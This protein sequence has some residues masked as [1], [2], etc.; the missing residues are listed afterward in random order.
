MPIEDIPRNLRLLCG[1]GRSVS[2]ICRQSGVNRH[3]MKRYLAGSSRP[4]LHTLRR[5]CD[6]FGVEEQELL[7]RHADFAALVR[8]RPPR[9]QRARDRAGEFIGAVTDRTEPKIAQRYVGYYHVYFQPDRLVNE[10][11]RAL[12]RVKLEDRCLVTKTL[13]RYPVGS[14][15]LA[16]AVKYEGIAF[17]SGNTLTVME[18]RPRAAESEFFSILYGADAGELTYLSGLALG[19]A[20]DSTRTIYALRL[21]WRY[22]GQDIDRRR[23]IAEC[24]QFP[25][26]SPEI[27]KYVR[28]CTK[29]DLPAAE[30][31]FSPRT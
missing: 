23:R 22:L 5:L 31:L 25:A 9:L 14:A 13:E 11:H 16:R 6:Y 29:N 27:G 8:I 15:G 20:P 10:V 26:D 7:L 1:Y 24:G 3:Q 4:S 19:V 2:E 17:A 30:P 18:R 28:Y 21:C 12:T